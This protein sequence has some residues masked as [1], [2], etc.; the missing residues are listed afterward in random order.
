MASFAGICR[1]GPWDGQ[2][3]EHWSDKLILFN[4]SAVDFNNAREP[5]ENHAV[6]CIGEYRLI[7]GQWIW[8]NEDRLLYG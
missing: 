4:Q 2:Q 8:H 5:W 6:E 3:Y 1:G 7:F